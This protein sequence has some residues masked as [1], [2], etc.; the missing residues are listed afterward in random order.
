MSQAGIASITKA[1]PAIPT[2]FV[3]DSGTAIPAANI[4]NVFGGAG[5]HTSAAG[6]TITITVVAAAFTWN[7]VTSA[8]NPITFAPE[9]GYITK[10][11][12]SVQFQLPPASSVGDS[13]RIVGYGNLWTVAQNANQS[14]NLG[15][16]T[17]T[18]GVTGSLTA[19]GIKDS[20][21]LVCVT[22]N[23][24]WEIVDVTGNP[25]FI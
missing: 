3:T 18:P 14:I 21:E 8:S 9:N 11:A 16:E 2:S 13:Y 24:E 19:T 6:N 25:S 4:L 1:V 15:I 10:G 5:A 23:L 12:G 7:I 17:T 22:A 20:V